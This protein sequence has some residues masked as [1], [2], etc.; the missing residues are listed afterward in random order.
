[1]SNDHEWAP[2]PESG[3]QEEGGICVKCHAYATSEGQDAC[4][5][6]EGDNGTIINCPDCCAKIRI[7]YLDGQ[8][9][10]VVHLRHIT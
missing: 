5:P 7:E 3:P 8:L 10:R 9:H 2:V 6:I 1:M 4:V